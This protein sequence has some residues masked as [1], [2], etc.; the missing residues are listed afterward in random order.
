M[1]LLMEEQKGDSQTVTRYGS[2][3]V[4]DW[5]GE[6]NPHAQCYTA[7]RQC[8]LGIDHGWRSYVGQGSSTGR[9]AH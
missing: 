9:Q 3:L 1:A 7:D 2:D 5:D 4:P 8:P 6:A